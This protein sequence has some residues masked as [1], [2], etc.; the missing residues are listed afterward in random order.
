MVQLDFLYFSFA[1]S[2]EF[3]ACN[4]PYF[5]ILTA[6][7]LDNH[8]KYCCFEHL[9][10][11]HTGYLKA[12]RVSKLLWW[13]M[14]YASVCTLTYSNSTVC[15]SCHY[16]AAF[17]YVEASGQLLCGSPQNGWGARLA[18]ASFYSWDATWIY[19]FFKWALVGAFKAFGGKYSR[20]SRR[21]A[22]CIVK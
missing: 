16:G 4:M 3:S 22:F 14:F 5:K 12:D 21:Y 10:I 19:I 18:K 1:K 11:I 13:L 2:V 15:S 8:E 9:N 17:R 7:L 20:L 6:V